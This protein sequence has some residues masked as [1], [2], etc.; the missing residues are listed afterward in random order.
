MPRT[1][2]QAGALSEMLRA[3]GASPL[4]VPTIAVEPPRTPAPMERAIKG[5]VSGRYQW[6]AFTSINAVKAVRESFEEYGLD[7]RAFCR[8]SRSPRSAR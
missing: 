7:A 3:H 6:I 4:E 2:E 1:R 8:A 5:L